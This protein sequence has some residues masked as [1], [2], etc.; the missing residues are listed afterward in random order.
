MKFRTMTLVFAI[1]LSPTAF[2]RAQQSNDV[3]K[4][5]HDIY[6]QLIETNTTESIGNMTTAADEM[7]TRLRA[8]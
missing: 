7:A 4:L 8:A 3:N 1:A 5:A 6:K 2:L